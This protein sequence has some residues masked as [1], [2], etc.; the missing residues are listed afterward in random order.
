MT[1]E[2]AEPKTSIASTGYL[3]HLGNGWGYSLGA[4]IADP[5]RL[6]VNMHGDGS[7]GFHIQELDTF[8]RFNLKILTV[9]ANNYG[10]GM[11]VNGQNLI[12][13]DKSKVRPST[14]LSKDCKYELVAQGFNCAGEIVKDYDQIKPAV[15][16]L[17]KSGKP[18]LINLIVSSQPTTPATLSMVGMTEDKNVIVVPYYD[19]VPRPFYKET[20]SKANGHV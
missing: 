16:K 18:G 10:W 3:G 6:V 1:L 7:A 5:S 15:E 13:S 4:A 2:A 20:G 17:T 14:Q 12:F 11:S 9:I 8:A 19:N